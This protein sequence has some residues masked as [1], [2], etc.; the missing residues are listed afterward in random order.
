MSA[1]LNLCQCCGDDCPKV[2]GYDPHLGAM[3]EPCFDGLMAGQGVLFAKAIK[4]VY[5]GPCG[6]N[7][8][9]LPKP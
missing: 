6:D 9:A 2:K 4:G 3:C 5:A 8:P 7:Q 1:I